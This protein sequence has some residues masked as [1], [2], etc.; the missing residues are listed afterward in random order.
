MA[1]TWNLRLEN[2]EKGR[3]DDRG[4]LK[5]SRNQ[6]AEAMMSSSILALWRKER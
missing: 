4:V 2:E 1:D 6:A 5:G 3:I